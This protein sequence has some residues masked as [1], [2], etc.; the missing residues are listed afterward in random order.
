MSVES[1]KISKGSRSH[2]KI[3]KRSLREK[4]IKL[5]TLRRKKERKTIHPLER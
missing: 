1:L 4:V 2:Y 3:G 5:E